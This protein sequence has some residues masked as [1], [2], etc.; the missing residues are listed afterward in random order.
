MVSSF[1]RFLTVFACLCL[2]TGIIGPASADQGALGLSDTQI[3]RMTDTQWLEY[4]RKHGGGGGARGVYKALVIYTNCE[5]AQNER[6]I[7]R[8]PPAIQ[9]RDKQLAALLQER[10]AESG[11]MGKPGYAGA[12]HALGARRGT[13]DLLHL[14]VTEQQQHQGKHGVYTSQEDARKQEQAAKI[15]TRLAAQN[16]DD[17]ASPIRGKI[18][19]L[20]EAWPGGEKLLVLKYFENRS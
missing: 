15:A 10:L 14:L 9:Q 1:R 4:Y 18:L 5:E 13:A 6:A 17:A 19:Q 12:S 2:P 16:A 20:V 7:K 11:V 8:L 3:L